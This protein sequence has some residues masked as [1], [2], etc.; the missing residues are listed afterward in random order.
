[1]RYCSQPSC[2]VLVQHGRCAKHAK[3]SDIGRRGTAKER[4]YDNNWHQ[5]SVRFRN[6]HPVCGERYDG[7]MDKIHSR[8]AQQG[9]DTLAQCVDH[10]IPKARGGTDDYENLMSACY[11]CNTWKALT[12]E[13]KT[14]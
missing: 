1:M 11:A 6:E 10:T 8:C 7:S 5:L 12:I 14:A 4:G 9:I 13:R 3:S 2:S